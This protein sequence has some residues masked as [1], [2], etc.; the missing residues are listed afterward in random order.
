MAS[1]GLVSQQ[2]KTM[3]QKVLEALQDPSWDFR[4]VDGIAK[5]TGLDKS[6]V[7][8]V[9]EKH[10]NVRKSVVPDRR[11]RELYTLKSR[12]VKGQEV[13]AM[14]RAFIAKSVR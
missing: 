9:L 7:R 12:G 13:L 11:G 1:P 10:P 14:A 8:Q 3:E 6:E 2:E 5:E 4:T